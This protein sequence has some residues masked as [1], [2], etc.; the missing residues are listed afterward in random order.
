MSTFA[1]ILNRVTVRLP[2][3]FGNTVWKY[4]VMLAWAG[5]VYTIIATLYELMV[6]NH[7][8]AQIIKQFE[9]LGAYV[10]YFD[11]FFFNLS[12][13][14]DV[15]TDPL[16][17]WIERLN[18]PYVEYISRFS[19]IA[20]L[21][22]PSALRYVSHRVWHRREGA[23]SAKVNAQVAHAQAQYDAAQRETTPESSEA[24]GAAVIFT[25]IGGFIG[26]V[27]GPVG[28][29]AGAAVG[30]AIG[31][32]AGGAASSAAG[33]TGAV[34]ARAALD[35]LLPIQESAARRTAL[36]AQR[37]LQSL[38]LLR[39]SAAAALL[40]G[41]AIVT[42]IVFYDA[43]NGCH[44]VRPVGDACSCA[45]SPGRTGEATRPSGAVPEVPDHHVRVGR[46][47]ICVL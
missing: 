29:V 18:I 3:G 45:A 36:S 34:R 7:L 37:F 15:I 16:V 31:V 6:F 32:A 22:I 28:I 42:D 1:N 5:L 41:L 21:L 39:V 46:R 8:I 43:R 4:S 44:T 17:A 2:L 19:V 25:I 12:R 40:L 35:A 11:D 9:S 30:G 33:S 13:G 10:R 23:N 38:A 20:T 14:W 47:N 26:S 27:A 24:G